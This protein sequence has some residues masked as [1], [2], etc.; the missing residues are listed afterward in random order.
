MKKIIRIILLAIALPL[1]WGCNDD[2]EEVGKN[3]TFVASAS[4]PVWQIDWT[5]ND[6]SPDWQDPA[7]TQ[8]E[9]SMNVLVELDD[10]FL[11]YSTVGDKMAMFINGECR[12]VSFRNVIDGERV[13]FLIH[14]KGRSEETSQHMELRYYSA[15]MKQ[16]F[17]DYNMPMFSPGNLMDEA[18]QLILTPAGCSTK[19][20]IYTEIYV[21]LPEQMPFTFSPDDQMAVFVGDECRGIFMSFPEDFN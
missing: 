4:R 16:L 3:S 1:L 9:C 8:F 20:P 15:G 5:W 6:G 12:G 14:V 11:P 2:N 21:R 17:I 18:H 7:S 19:Y 10:C 13:L